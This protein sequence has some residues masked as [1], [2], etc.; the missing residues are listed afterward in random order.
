MSDQQVGPGGLIVRSLAIAVAV[1]ALLAI[2]FGIG[3][4]MDRIFAPR[5]S[6]PTVTWGSS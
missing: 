6:S 1:I 2:G 3:E 4:L 5:D